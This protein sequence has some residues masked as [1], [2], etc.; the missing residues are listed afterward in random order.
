MIKPDRFASTDKLLFPGPK[1]LDF[2]AQGGYITSS[3]TYTYTVSTLTGGTYGFIRGIDLKFPPIKYPL[4]YESA[5]YVINGGDHI[6][7]ITV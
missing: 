5:G 6:L 7:T 3:T 1:V 2:D 4:N